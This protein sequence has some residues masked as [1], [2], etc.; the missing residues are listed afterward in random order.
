MIAII[1]QD[2]AQT[3]TDIDGNVYNTVTIGTQVWLKENLMTTK[4]ND[5]TAI[6]LV[7]NSIA[8]DTITTPA[9]CNYNNTTNTD[10]IN[11]YGRLY[12]WY[13]VNTGKL[14]PKGWHVADTTEWSALI[15]HLGGDSVAGE[16]LKE[17][18]TTH[19]LSPNTGADNNSG[20]TALP[21][22]C[23]YG[24]NY[25]VFW[26]FGNYAGFWVA[27]K[28]FGDYAWYHDINYFNTNIYKGVSYMGNGFSVR[29]LKD[30]TTGINENGYN[31]SLKIY[32]NP[33]S[34]RI[35]VDCTILQN[36]KISI[37]NSIGKLI[38][39]RQLSNGKNEIDL[40][41]FSK[42]IY[43]IKIENEQGIM[44]QKLIKE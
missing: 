41:N 36:I 8:W 25:G 4:Y 16:H 31:K 17:A 40:S 15:T 20:F 30:I 35:T 22:G 1:L 11:I 23:R 9:Y 7:T 12:N 38:L 32:P 14:C 13:A 3:V 44:Q 42:G 10:T 6:P 39:Q 5:S 19:W 29:C 26:D 27:T 43:I 18:G 33:A 28:S 24:N 21:A 37:Y 34:N 2:Q